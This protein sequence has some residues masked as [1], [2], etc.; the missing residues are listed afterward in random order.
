M[1]VNSAIR[2]MIRN[3]SAVL[4][5]ILLVMVAIFFIASSFT[6]PSKSDLFVKR[7]H[8]T[9]REIGHHVL[10]HAGDSTSRVMPVKETAE[11][12]FLLEFEKEFVFKPDTLVALTQRL[13]AKTD[14]S[15]YAVTVHECLKAGIVYGFQ[16]SPPTNSIE[17]CRGRSQP[18]GCY[19]IEIAFANFN[20]ST[21]DYTPTNLF[22]SGLLFLFGLVLIVKRFEKRKSGLRKEGNQRLTTNSPN[23]ALP[24]LG[25]F[26]FDIH[27]QK[28]LLGDETIV[29]TDKECKIL[30]LL[31]QNFGQLTS[32][33]DLIQ[34]IW[35]NEGVITGRSLDMFVS[36]LRKKL[37]A[38]LELRITNIHRKG[39][40]LEAV[41]D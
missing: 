21:T 35:T 36:K 9:I 16:I 41:I 33:E 13:L 26:A 1:N 17:P 30:E 12:V 29:L 24:T 14:L 40:K 4:G 27:H 28:L 10:L 5:G 6:K 22:L 25:K 23:T 2:F 8:L 31:N 7:V 11:G 39:Y 37:S 15:D 19:T 34:E 3:R 18:K 20:S 38:D 32:R